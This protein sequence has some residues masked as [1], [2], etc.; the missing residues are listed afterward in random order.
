MKPTAYYKRLYRLDTTANQDFH[1]MIVI[2]YINNVFA[3]IQTT[4]GV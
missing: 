4:S 3:H 2:P 1:V